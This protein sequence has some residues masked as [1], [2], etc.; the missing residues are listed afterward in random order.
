MPVKDFILASGSPQRKHLLEQ[1]GYA[2]KKIDPADID[3]SVK[4]G[5]AATAYVKRMSI[6]KA[7]KISQKNPNE[8]VLGSDTIV[9]VGRTILHKSKNDEEQTKVMEL[10][11]GK[12]H[13]VITS[14]CVIDKSGKP[15][16]RVVAT[17]ILMKKLSQQEILDYVATHEWVGAVGYKVEG[18]LAAFV[19]KIIGSYSGVVGLPLF[20]ARNLLIGAGVK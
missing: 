16:V 7:L 2:P 6:E 10:L 12:A 13:K 15:S 4:K 17:R 5:E 20:E 9:V 1:I 14:V 3:E 8:V 11:S 19:K 18:C